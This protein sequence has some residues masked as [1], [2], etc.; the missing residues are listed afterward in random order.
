VEDG[1]IVLI[2]YLMCESRFGAYIE[3]WVNK[4]MMPANKKKYKDV[5]LVML[6]C[7]CNKPTSQKALHNHWSLFLSS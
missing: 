5:P 1:E 2:A 6:S 4:L 7:R 3:W